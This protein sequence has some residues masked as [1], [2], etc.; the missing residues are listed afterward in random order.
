MADIIHGIVHISNRKNSHL[1]LAIFRCL[2]HS[3]RC[4]PGACM[5]GCSI[6][7]SVRFQA[8][9]GQAEKTALPGADNLEA[10]SYSRR[11]ILLWR[12]L[13]SLFEP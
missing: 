13:S 9:Q 2:V 4:L 1:Y 3:E 8:W 6:K 12:A 11:K 7:A 10:F 5:C